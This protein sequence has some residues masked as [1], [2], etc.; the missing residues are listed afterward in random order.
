M[1]KAETEKLQRIVEFIR[2][3]KTTHKEAREMIQAYANEQS[4]E[5]A[6]WKSNQEDKG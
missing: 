6:K 5:R 1:N 2:S 3:H 4:R